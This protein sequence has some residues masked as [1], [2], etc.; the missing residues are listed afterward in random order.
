MV[1]EGQKG[2]STYQ[3]QRKAFQSIKKEC[4]K[5]VFHRLA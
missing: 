5:L 2:D 3:E 4:S 1:K